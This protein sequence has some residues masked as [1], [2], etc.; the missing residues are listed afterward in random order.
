VCYCLWMHYT[1]Y[2]I[3]CIIW[4]IKYLILLMHGATMKITWMQFS[5]KKPAMYRPVLL[6]PTKFLS[7]AMCWFWDKVKVNFALCRRLRNMRN[8]G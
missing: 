3:E 4:T 7:S 2:I 6:L 8:S 5:G 1:F